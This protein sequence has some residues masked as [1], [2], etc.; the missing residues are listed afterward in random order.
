MEVV[1]QPSI[2]EKK[3]KII[4]DFAEYASSRCESIIDNA[5]RSNRYPIRK[6]NQVS[7][8]ISIGSSEI[9]N[10]GKDMVEKFTEYIDKIYQMLI[11]E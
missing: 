3:Q 6:K 2:E 8:G 1:S 10:L 7:K 4:E 11:K 5:K 9:R